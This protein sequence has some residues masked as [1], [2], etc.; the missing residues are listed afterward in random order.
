MVIDALIVA[1]FYF[2]VNL[3]Q[4][5]EIPTEIKKSLRFRPYSLFI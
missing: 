5:I 2:L 4:F 3:K 1:N